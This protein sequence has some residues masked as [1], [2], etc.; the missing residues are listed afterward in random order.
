MEEIIVEKECIEKSGFVLRLLTEVPLIFF[1]LN[2]NRQVI[3][4]NYLL[5][6]QLGYNSLDDVLG[7]RPGELFRC[8]HAFKNEAGC[9]TSKDCQVCGA[10]NA[11]LESDKL[12]SLVQKEARLTT[13]T[14]DVNVSHDYEVASKPFDWE[15]KRF[16]IVTLRNIDDLKKRERLERTFFHDI[17]NRAGILKG[18]TELLHKNQ[19]E[20]KIKMLIE[21]LT[22]EVEET[23]DEIL[24][25]QRLMEAEQGVLQV[26][27]E[28]V[29]AFTLL[30][31]LKSEFIGFE[32]KKNKVILIDY[33]SPNKEFLTDK[34]LLKR[35]LGNMIKNALE[36]IKSGEN[37]WIG[38]NSTKSHIKF[39]V[40]NPGV[41]SPDTQSQIFQ[42]SFSTKGKGRGIGTYSIKLF[43]E[44]YLKGK[45]EFTSN[46][47]EG[48]IFTVELPI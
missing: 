23:V 18:L 36:E 31:D 48:T 10:V 13:I 35:I 19:K 15:G 11:I 4:S 16:F 28:K 26:E 5:L 46:E 38:A 40:Q 1:I 45:V 6:K 42:R 8:I 47:K 14:G 25:Q 30:E 3:F 9:G 44:Q 39:W 29:N 34:I 43:S 33:S 20:E 21:V 17:I 41:I 37:I 7:F 32:E 2:R 12:N 22:K 24:Y 27:F